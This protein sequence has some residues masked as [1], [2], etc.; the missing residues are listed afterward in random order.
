MT[1][2]LIV[3]FIGL[4]FEALGVVLLKQGIDKIVRAEASLQNVKEIPLTFRNG[5]KLFVRGIATG[6]VLLGVA[7]EAV[8]FAALL[9]L[10]GKTDVSFVWPM[11]SLSFVMTTLASIV[12]LNERVT[13]TKW[14]GILLIMFGASLITWSEKVKEAREKAAAATEQTK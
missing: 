13:G 10:M 1:K 6:R 3:L 8:F 11:T 9:V 2:I 14:A 5:I 4:I 7:F 12:V